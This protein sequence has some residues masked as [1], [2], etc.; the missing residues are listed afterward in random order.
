MDRWPPE[1]AATLTTAL[2]ESAAERRTSSCSVSQDAVSV[3]SM[4][5]T[6][7]TSGGPAAKAGPVAPA[8]TRSAAASRNTSVERVR[9]R[10]I[11]PCTA[12]S[13]IL[14]RPGNDGGFGASRPQEQATSQTVLPPRYAMGKTLHRLPRANRG[15]SLTRRRRIDAAT[16][17]D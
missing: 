3:T 17:A 13:I 4:T 2:P 6:T 15:V 9:R 14:A 12:A 1:E 16:P 8:R 7:S 10:E 5:R 11:H